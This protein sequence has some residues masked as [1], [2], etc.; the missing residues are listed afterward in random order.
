MSEA[1]IHLDKIIEKLPDPQCCGKEAERI[2]NSDYTLE[3][4]RI[5]DRP[6][7]VSCWYCNNCG[8]TWTPIVEND[9]LVFWH[10]DTFEEDYNFIDF[11]ENGMKWKPE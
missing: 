1:V 5:K 11:M 7:G 2:I 9:K 3:E 10:Y 6:S 4:K 8:S